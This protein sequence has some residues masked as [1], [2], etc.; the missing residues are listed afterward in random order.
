MPSSG[1]M[2][3]AAATDARDVFDIDNALCTLVALG[4]SDLHCKVQ[5][6]PLTRV[7]GELRPIDGA[8]QL[9]PADTENAVR[10]MLQDP[11]KL[12]ELADEHEVDF[13]YSISGVARFRVNAFRQR[14]ALSLV[15]RA[16]P[17]TIRSVAELM[18][19]PVIT[20]LA[21]EER[22]IILLTGTTGS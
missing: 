2:A 6:A 4:G 9:T 14:G 17:H 19:P 20:E 3:C 7:D 1:V 10:T 18:L 15:C 21:K 8:D 5:V 12:K 22:G 11:V 16:I 13:S